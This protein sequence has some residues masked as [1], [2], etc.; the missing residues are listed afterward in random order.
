MSK[1]YVENLTFSVCY[2]GLQYFLKLAE[3]A[4]A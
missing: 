2:F 1:I 3:T 4:C